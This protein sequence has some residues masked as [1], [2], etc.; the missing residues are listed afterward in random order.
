MK[1][2]YNRKY[3]IFYDIDSYTCALC[4]LYKGK[5]KIHIEELID[6]RM[7]VIAVPS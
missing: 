7:S 4:V 1:E 6:A 2:M 3:I 5:K